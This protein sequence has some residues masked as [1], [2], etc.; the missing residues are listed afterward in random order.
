M[1]KV[2]IVTSASGAGGT[3]VGREI[4]ALLD[5]PFHQLDAL[6]WQPGWR[7]PDPDEFSESESQRSSQRTAG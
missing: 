3:T 2:A 4:A 7:E 6:F 5:L 1:R